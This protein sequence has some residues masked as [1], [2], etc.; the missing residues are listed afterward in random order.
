MTIES[1]QYL[2]GQITGGNMSTSTESANVNSSETADKI[3]HRG[4]AVSEEFDHPYLNNTTGQLSYHSEK[5]SAP[6]LVF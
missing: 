4:I 2:H 3:L 1:N 5:I 6:I